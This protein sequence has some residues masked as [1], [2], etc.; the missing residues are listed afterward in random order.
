[1][2]EGGSSVIQVQRK[3]VKT[4]KC[5]NCGALNERELTA[6]QDEQE[7]YDGDK[8]PE[9]WVGGHLEQAGKYVGE[10]YATHHFCRRV[11]RDDFL[12]KRIDAITKMFYL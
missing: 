12:T 1:M 2:L 5:D 6:T 10:T 4:C 11:C 9:G 8:L 3:V 7:S